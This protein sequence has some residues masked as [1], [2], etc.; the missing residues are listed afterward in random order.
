MR[1]ADDLLQGEHHPIR[2]RLCRVGDSA[3]GLGQPVQESVDG[4]YGRG[5]H[6]GI[7]RREVPIHRLPDDTERGG[8]VGDADA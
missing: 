8:D 7:G 2:H 3:D 5:A 1:D 4:R 6:Q